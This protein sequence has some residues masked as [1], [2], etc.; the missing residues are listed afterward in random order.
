MTIIPVVPL[1]INRAMSPKHIV[2]GVTFG[3]VKG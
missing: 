1:V 2:Q 3:A